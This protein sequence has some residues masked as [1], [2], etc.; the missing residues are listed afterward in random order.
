MQRVSNPEI[1]DSNHCPPGEAQISLRDL[2]RINR[3]FGGVA[4]TRT[5]VEAVCAETGARDLS[6]LEVAA[7]RG[8]VPRVAARQLA[9]RG[10]NLQISLSD[11]VPAHLT[12]GDHEIAADAL[13]LPFRDNA[14]D[15]VSCNL[16][17]HHLEPPELE[18]FTQ[19]ALRVSRLALL[20][21][22][23]IR[24]SLHLALVYAGFALMKSPVSR[25]DGVV[26]VKRAYLPGEIAAM[27]S[28]DGSRRI[29]ISRHYL[30]RMGVIVWKHPRSGTTV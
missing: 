11:R 16:F 13:Q 23:L 19:E 18:R 26:S 3:W 8:E 20:I 2:D 25:H 12:Q 9:R 24:S 17:A 30:F 6:L 27:L 21:N 10:I 22:D 4:T 29:E 28:N 1:L 5:L 15:L 7:G 14:F